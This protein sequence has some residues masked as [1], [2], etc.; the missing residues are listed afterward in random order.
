[1]MLERAL[2]TI[3]S[4]SLIGVAIAILIALFSLASN[5]GGQSA[6]AAANEQ[7]IQKLEDNTITRREMDD[8]K[9]SLERIE[10][11]LDRMTAQRSK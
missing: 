7:R 3:K 1:M 8:V 6:R 5:Y 4:P 2:Q 10:N 9:R 11:K